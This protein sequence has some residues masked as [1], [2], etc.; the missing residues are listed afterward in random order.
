MQPAPLA[1][2]AVDGITTSACTNIDLN[3]NPAVALTPPGG[4]FTNVAITPNLQFTGCQ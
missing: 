2:Y 1:T 3:S 4:P